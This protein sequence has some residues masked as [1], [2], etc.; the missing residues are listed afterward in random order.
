MDLL[1]FF[2]RKANIPC[3]KKTKI[4]I[5]SNSLTGGGAERAM[6]EIANELFYQGIPVNLVVLNDSSDD[7]VQVNCPIHKMKRTSP[8]SLVQTLYAFML[9]YKTIR[10]INP[11][12]IVL[13]CDLPELFG[14]CLFF[15]VK[16]LVIEHANPAWST[17]Q[18]IGKI[19]RFRLRQ[20]G[21]MFAGVS[22]H[23]L[24]WP[25]KNKPAA[26]LP[27][28]VRPQQSTTVLTSSNLG[29]KRL[30]F[31]GRLATEQK[32]PQIVLE[33]SNALN[34]PALFI[35]EGPAKRNLAFLAESQGL[36]IMF[37]GYQSNPWRIV[38]NGDLLIV[39]S[40]FEGDGLVVVEGIFNGIPM[41]LSDIPEFRRFNLQ[42]Q[43]YCNSIEAFT[44]R[45]LQYKD[46]I[47][48]FVPPEKIRRE[49]IT[50]RSP[51]VV[52]ECWL[53]IL[54]SSAS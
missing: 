40:K 46:Q 45:I 21:A 32:N 18:F 44:S 5:V 9:F 47:D 31:I 15:K 7:L 3:E 53:S 37:M 10:K 33:L 41:L 14:S 36:D 48:T 17:R 38:E 13:N 50:A 25:T 54:K 8:R 27:N 20:K 22:E 51:K 43:A 29:I 34:I 30:V 6:N 23:L 16:L 28:I 39:P 49:L 2:M 12:L 26:I 35:G 24:V 4:V 42:N 19:V 11:G 52:L 1:K